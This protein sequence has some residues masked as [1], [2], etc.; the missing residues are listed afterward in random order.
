MPS[1]YAI[2]STDEFI[3]IISSN[4]PKGLM[5]SLDVESLYTNVPVQTTINIVLDSVY[6]HD[7]LPPPKIPEP[8]LKKLINVCTTRAPF[9]HINGDIYLQ[10]DGLAMGSPLSCTM[11]NF[12]ISH[13]ENLVLKTFQKNPRFTAD[14]SMIFFAL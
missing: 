9:C 8:T 2:R 1:Q 13:V 11:A 12:Y 4:K 10:R 14:T 5:A 6:H 3:Q 7:S